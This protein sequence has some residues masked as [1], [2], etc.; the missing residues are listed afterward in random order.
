[1]NK[2]I[3]GLTA[4][5]LLLGVSGCGAPAETTPVKEVTPQVCLDALDHS[6]ELVNLV[7]EVIATNSSANRD[8]DF[9]AALRKLDDLR[10]RINAASDSWVKA[11]DQC[12]AKA[13]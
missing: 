13:K 2:T 10:P 11:S 8:H 12:R 6:S 4:A 5:A 7:S 1:M 3:A 9:D